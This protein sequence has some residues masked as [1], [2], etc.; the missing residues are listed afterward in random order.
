MFNEFSMIMRLLFSTFQGFMR[1]SSCT[2]LA[3]LIASLLPAQATDNIVRAKLRQVALGNAS[4]VRAELPDLLRTYP[5]DAGMQFLN[6]TLMTDGVKALPQF[7]RIVRENPQ[8]IWA[9]DAQWRVVQIYALRKDT[10]NARSELQNF[11]RNYPTSEFLLFAAE[12]VKSTVGLPPTFTTYRN[13][14]VVAST[15]RSVPPS[16]ASGAASKPVEKSVEKPVEKTEKSVE[17][18]EKP[19][20]KPAEKASDKLE[21]SSQN[22]STEANSEERYTLQV[23]IYSSRESAIADVQKLLKA[24]LRSDVVE[25]S[26]DGAARFAVTVGN[27]S[28]REAAEKAK[29]VVQKACTCVPFVIVKK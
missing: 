14:I 5:N 23:G 4:D 21:A 7:V 18:V 15:A 1:F 26:T 2:V 29:L 17:K 24:R 6:A 9:D 27:Y 20:E 22:T 13:P 25:K 11:R 10:T 16:S 28:S 8:S 12:I 19:V 3:M